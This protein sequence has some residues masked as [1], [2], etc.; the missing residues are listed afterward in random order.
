MQMKI[1]KDIAEKK[2]VT[3]G[4]MSRTELIRAIQRTEGYSDCFATTHVNECNQVNCMWRVDCKAEVFVEAD[5][6]I[7]SSCI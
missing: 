3:P 1:I 4:N 6:P 5:L 7:V 2:G